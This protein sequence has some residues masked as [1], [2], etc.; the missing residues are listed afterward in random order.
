[1]SEEQKPAGEESAGKK[2]RGTSRK[3]KALNSK[4]VKLLSRLT[5][6]DS[7]AEAGRQAGYSVRQ[8]AHIG[9][10]RAYRL[11]PAVFNRHGLTLD[12][13]A[14]DVNRLRK[15]K[16]IQYFAEKGIVLDQREHE[17][18]DIQAKAVDM[19]LRVHGAYD[20]RDDDRNSN[21]HQSHRHSIRVVVSDVT[22]AKALSQLFAARGTTGIVLDV[23][24]KVDEDLG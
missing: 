22:A 14:E 7:V 20:A 16:R 5:K 17:A 18:A 23:G 9:L 15:M 10:Q 2:R 8:S 1:M 21:G 13:L 6:V 24:E 4:Q 11:A 12:S 3:P 19:G